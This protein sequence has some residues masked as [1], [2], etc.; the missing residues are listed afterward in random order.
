MDGLERLD[1]TANSE[2]VVI[3]GAVERSDDQ[4]DNTKMVVVGLLLSFCHLSCF[5]FFSLQSFH[6]FFSFLVLVNHDIA[7]TKISDDN[8]SEA[9]HVVRIFVDNWF[10]IPDSF[11]VSLQNEEDVSHIQLPDFMVCTEL[12]TLS[13]QFL[14]D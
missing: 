8:S 12:C 4:I 10:I 5:L 1:D 11:I 3:F 14:H 13:E 9:E 2:V 6:D 7:D